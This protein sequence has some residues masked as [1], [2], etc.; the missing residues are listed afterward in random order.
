MKG[1]PGR[2][3]PVP[4]ELA[5]LDDHQHGRAL[6]GRDVNE[7]DRWPYAVEVT[8]VVRRK[9]GFGVEG[10][11]VADLRR[12]GCDHLLLYSAAVRWGFWAPGT[13]PS[14]CDNPGQGRFHAPD[15]S[16][17]TAD[18]SERAE[19]MTAP[20]TANTR[21]ASMMRVGR[22]GSDPTRVGTWVAAA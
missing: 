12:R 6:L 13:H 10:H 1:D 17:D 16:P 7:D 18:A 2:I 20:I 3:G 22:R 8:E 11:R 14:R 5:R 15:P 19:F 9:H 4:S 21:E